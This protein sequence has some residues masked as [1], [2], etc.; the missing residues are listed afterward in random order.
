MEV[1]SGTD[2]IL[3]LTAYNE[4]ITNDNYL[5]QTHFF[6]GVYSFDKGI[7][8]VML[9]LSIQNTSDRAIKLYSVFP[10]NRN[11]N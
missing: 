11:V 9:N 4:F 3:Q 1:I 5:Q 2:N 8:S 10:G 6:D 7:V